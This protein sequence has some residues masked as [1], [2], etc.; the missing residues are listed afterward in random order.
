M[1]QN[2]AAH[3]FQELTS[4]GGQIMD[5]KFKILIID[6]ELLMCE[7]LTELLSIQGYHTAAANSGSR[8]RWLPGRSSGTW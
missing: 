2:S 6:D 3:D 7:S 8:D 5:P 1:L 4:K